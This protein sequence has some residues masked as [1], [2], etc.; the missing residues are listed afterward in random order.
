MEPV[1]TVLVTAPRMKKTKTFQAPKGMHDILPE[2]QKYWRYVLKKAE[3]LLEDY[4]FEKISTPILETSELFSRSVGEATDIVEKETYSFKT[5]GGDELTLRP[6]GTA[7]V[8]R[9]YLENGL[10]VRP[11]PIKL[12]YVEP[13]FR[14]DQPQQGRYRQF[15]QLGVE[16][17]GDSSEAVDAELLFLGYKLLE[18]LGLKGYT[19]HVNSIGDANCRPAYIRALK[20]YYKS[21]VKK[22]CPQ[23]KVRMKDNILRVLDC[24]EEVCKEVIK[25]APQMMDF[26]DEECKNHFKHV[27]EF[28][29]EAKIPYMLNPYLVRG[30]DYYTRTVF[31]FLPEENITSQSTLI[32]GGRYDRLVDLLGGPKTP[33]AGWA[34]GLE[35]IVLALKEKNVNVPDIGPKPKVFLSQLGEVAKRRSLLLYEEIRKAGIEIKSSL[36]R[37]SIK[38]QLRIANRLGVKF[39]LIFGQKEALDST[40][41]LREMDAGVQETIPLEKIVDELKKRLKK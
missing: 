38:A 26:L 30:L 25:E 9:A 40:V 27:L 10:H 22:I 8:I 41:I 37:D 32:A 5:K 23:C 17:I 3:S 39:A 6:E 15:H 35:R 11:H 24:N 14:H 13:M 2:D 31:E 19:I 1:V 12:Y 4:G 36:G 28:L 7:P 29:D 34:M 18:S 21:K 20:D 16:T 33:A